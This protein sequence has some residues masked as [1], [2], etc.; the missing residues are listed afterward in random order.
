MRVL[1]MKKISLLLAVIMIFTSSY[2][3]AGEKEFF[4]ESMR[5]ILETGGKVKS[6]TDTLKPNTRLY[7][8]KQL[9]SMKETL[10]TGMQTISDIKAQAMEEISN[11][12]L[13]TV[14]QDTASIQL[15]T[16]NVATELLEIY[17]NNGAISERDYRNVVS[18]YE[19]EAK[20]L[21]RSL[22][23]YKNM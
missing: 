13:Q 1:L 4:Q 19:K 10:S 9:P 22:E 16:I 20:R 14:L 15:L 5:T 6:I 18:K 11:P 2:V 3:F 21:Q 23:K 8:Y 7:I 17:E 12:T